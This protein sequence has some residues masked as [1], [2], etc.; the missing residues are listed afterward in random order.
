MS[1][2]DHGIV[3][4]HGDMNDPGQLKNALK[5]A[6]EVD[7]YF[8]LGA[9]LPNSNVGPL[10][11]NA[12]AR[13]N[14]LAT[15]MLLDQFAKSKSR[16]FIYASSVTVIG[17]PQEIPIDENHP[18]APDNSYSA[19]KLASEQFCEALRRRTGRSI[20]SLRIASPYGPGMPETTVLSL[21]VKAAL[22]GHNLTLLG[23][24]SRIQTFVH[25]R[26]VVQ[27]MIKASDGPGGVFN[28]GGLAISMKELAE[29]VIAL[30]PESGSTVAY[31]E[32]KDPQ[33]GYCWTFNLTRAAE[34]IGYLPEVD[35]NA[36]LLEYIDLFRSKKKYNSWWS[37]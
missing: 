22:E 4:L 36:G 1:A 3:T 24:G 11:S 28:V 23:T 34:Q 9:L 31:L 19:S 5:A 17:V 26:D 12:Y 10:I 7:V 32:K 18:T 37:D 29:K 33:E 21:F 15:A 35:L 8:H 14:V 30:A 2:K 6:G 13:V 27:A 20:S 25:V 16:A